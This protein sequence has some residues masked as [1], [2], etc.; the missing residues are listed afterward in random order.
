MAEF[1]T[2]EQLPLANSIGCA[3]PFPR[4]SYNRLH[5]LSL[6]LSSQNLR[7]VWHPSLGIKFIQSP[8]VQ[9]PGSSEKYFVDQ[10]LLLYVGC[11]LMSHWT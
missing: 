10:L 5:Y 8:I 3:L 7:S 9:I 6:W 11:R 2:Y 4:N 1:H